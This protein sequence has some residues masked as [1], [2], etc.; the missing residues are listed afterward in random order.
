ML[1]S[2]SGIGHF[3]NNHNFSARI[4]SSAS[5]TAFLEYEVEWLYE[6]CSELSP[7]APYK[8]IIFMDGNVVRLKKR[9]FWKLPEL[10]FPYVT[11]LFKSGKMKLIRERLDYDSSVLASVFLNGIPVRKTVQLKSKYA[12]FKRWNFIDRPMQNAIPSKQIRSTELIQFGEDER[13]PKE[14]F[15]I[16][17]LRVEEER[18]NIQ[19]V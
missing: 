3:K 7:Y 14:V 10:P 17:E 18:Q 5:I 19:L 13:S 15:R 2:R 9:L 1:E 6:S 4:A 12:R 11:F 16:D 8:K